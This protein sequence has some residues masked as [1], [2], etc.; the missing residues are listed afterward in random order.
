MAVAFILSTSATALTNATATSGSVDTTGATLFVAVLSA[1]D[2][3]VANGFSDS[4]GNSWNYLTVL[5]DVG[6]NE[7]QATIAYAWSSLSVG[8][9]HTFSYNNGSYPGFVLF[10][11]SGTETG[12]S[13]FDQ[14]NGSV[15]AAGPASY[16][17][18]SI[19]P[20]TDG[21]V[22]VVGAVNGGAGSDYS[23]TVNGSYSTPVEVFYAGSIN[24]MA[25]YWIQTTATATNPTITPSVDGRHLVKIASFKASGGGGSS[26]PSPAAGTLALAGTG[27]VLGFAILMPDEL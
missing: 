24:V 11:F 6:G 12:S 18:G 7:M 3:N 1:Y 14:Q 4:K 21:Q 15:N 26:T 22:A 23:Y 13:P 17:P 16:Q 27:S 19:T 20:S 2:I 5:D 10:A 25:S 8:S 9:G